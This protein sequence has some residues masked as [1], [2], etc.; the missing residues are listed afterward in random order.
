MI[1]LDKNY[2]PQNSGTEFDKDLLDSL[3]L[4]IYDAYKLLE[5]QSDYE[6]SLQILC[7]SLIPWTCQY[8]ALI[9]SGEYLSSDH[10]PSFEVTDNLVNMVK[11][12]GPGKW[13]GFTRTAAGYFMEHNT[14]VLS[15]EAV[16]T[17]NRV[18]NSKDQ[19]MVRV[20]GNENRLEYTDALINIRNRFAHSRSISG[21][22]ARELYGDYFQIW[23]AWINIVKEVFRL[24]LLYSTAPENPMIAF[25]TRPFEKSSL[26]PEIDRNSIILYDEKERTHIRLY[27][28]IVTYTETSGGSAELAFLEEIKSRYLFYL[29]GENFF[30]LKDE[31]QILSKMIE[32]K[33][34]TE[35]VVTAQDLTIKTFAE[36][37]DRIT[38]QT[39]TGFK[40]ALKYIPE[41]YIDRPALTGKLNSWL[42]SSLPACILTGDPGTGKTSLI[43]N[44][45]IN[46]REEG[47][48]V[49]L[50]E[51]S[52][53]K[54]SD[55]TM[56]IEKELNLGSPLKECLDAIQ[57]Q[58]ITSSGEGNSKKFIIVIDAVNEFIGKENENRTRLWREINTLAGILDLYKPVL[59]CLVTTRTD[60]WSVDF[61]E[62]ST[63][64]DIL[65][66]KLYWRD[67]GEGFPRIMLGDLTEDE[68]GE[69]FEKARVTIPSMAV[70]NSFD[71]LSEK[72]KKV[73]CN[74]FLMRLALVTY[75]EKRMPALTRNKIERK[76]AKAKI[77]E[78]KDKTTV[79]FALLERMSELKKTEVTFDE[80]LSGQT[81]SMFRK[82]VSDKDRVNLEKLIFDPRPT[83]PYK[84]LLREGIIEERSDDSTI[85]S[86]EKIRFS[87][88]KI[89]DIIYPEFLMRTFKEFKIPLLVVGISLL[90]VV[91]SNIMDFKA[92]IKENVEKVQNELKMSGQKPENIDQISTLSSDLITRIIYLKTMMSGST[93]LFLLVAM[94]GFTVIAIYLRFFLAKTSKTDLPTKFVTEKFNV[95]LQEQNRKKMFYP[96][97]LL[98]GFMALSV[99][100]E[101]IHKPIPD[102][103]LYIILCI[104]ILG[105]N[106]GLS[107]FVVLKNANSPQEAFCMFGRQD[108]INQLAGVVISIPLLLFLNFGVIQI[109]NHLS[110]ESDE[111]YQSAKREWES[112]ATVGS[113]RNNDPEIFNV[114]DQKLVKLEKQAINSDF[115]RKRSSS[116]AFFIGKYFFYA[117]CIM[118][119]V[120]LIFRYLAGFWLFRILKRRLKPVETTD[121]N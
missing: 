21:E 24:R 104:L 31:F 116:R 46:R 56:I 101:N 29:Q 5:N 35:D 17:L 28:V 9:L 30:R 107:F 51:A 45:C 49:L 75:S 99:W 37:I 62:R 54:E 74:P 4:P 27:P 93:I 106:M 65:K 96:V 13:I 61:P 50:L 98:G 63:A 113:L 23:K 115:S 108:L 43:A 118:Y 36:R 80:F 16:S 20:P 11:K 66:E 102:L 8:I 89:I 73:L 68:A 112:A 87:Q 59:K 25:D 60:L 15:H 38:G 32:S 48:H 72:A 114:I 109:S 19:P 110:V 7:L 44:F 55:I 105:W 94:G 78:E 95:K 34:I 85:K 79:L 111:K 71:E 18:L 76:Y 41:M 67:N 3:P 92:S 70:N 82:K 57:K 83:S 69:I 1:E 119:P 103:V 10:E 26:P 14:K 120:Y 91:G 40:D 58:N 64:Y 100:L 86:K 22:K 6:K 12:P 84:K 47:D 90:L 117:F 81:K 88:E 121:H 52:S 33:T 77:T 39:I 97:I 42:K 53:L 2:N